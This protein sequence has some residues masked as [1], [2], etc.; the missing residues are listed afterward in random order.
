MYLWSEVRK[1]LFMQKE[2][3]VY[4]KESMIF[5]FVYYVFFSFFLYSKECY[6]RLRE[7]GDSYY[8]FRI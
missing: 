5:F 6:C 8:V 7:F 4:D 1:G 3:G 2:Y